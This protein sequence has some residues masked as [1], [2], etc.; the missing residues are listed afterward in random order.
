MRALRKANRLLVQSALWGFFF[1]VASSRSGENLMNLKRFQSKLKMLYLFA[2]GVAVATQISISFFELN[3]FKKSLLELLSARWYSWSWCTLST[4]FQF[5]CLS[6]A[7]AALWTRRFVP[8]FAAFQ[9]LLLSLLNVW[10]GV[11]QRRRSDG[12][13]TVEERFRQAN[14]DRAGCV[15]LVWPPPPAVERTHPTKTHRPTC[16][17]TT[18]VCVI[19]MRRVGPQSVTL[20]PSQK[21]E[22]T[23]WRRL[24]CPALS[25]WTRNR[26]TVYTAT[27]SPRVVR[28][29]VSHSL[30]CRTRCS[31]KS[32]SC[33][34]G[35][36]VITALMFYLSFPHLS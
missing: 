14:A 8:V 13:G 7:I 27:L 2:H 10:F 30:P 24:P 4:L 25:R 1:R 36:F 31:T 16:A 11:R 29:S 17:L 26:I 23:P 19:S 21:A 32:F 15:R 34:G 28:Q 20:W 12:G 5:P 33:H 9:R 22:Q 35:F 18:S 6:V 3:L